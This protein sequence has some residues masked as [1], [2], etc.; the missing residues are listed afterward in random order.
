M[1]FN[2]LHRWD[3]S[4]TEA[5]ALQNQLVPHVIHDQPLDL[6]KIRTI[7]GVDVSVKTADGGRVTSDQ[8]LNAISSAAVVV[9]SFPSLE[10]I[11]TVTASI[12][13]PFPYVPGLLAF[14]EGPVLQEAFAQ[15]QTEPDAL[16]FDG[17][18]R[19]HPRRLGIACHLGLWL[20]KPT[21]GCGKTL[22]V[23]T[24]I[25]PEAQ[26]GA[27]TDL[28][29][30]GE[31]VGVS[32]RSKDKVKPIFISCGHLIDLPSSIALTLQCTRDYRLPEPIRQA[33]NA[34]GKV[35]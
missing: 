9:L 24:Y 32:L 31:V 21:L 13:T 29:D 6:S 17:M 7:A 28:V 33:H 26:R 30:K 35:L 34:A 15:L 14:R 27:Y 2:I 19:A 10:V 16:M 18:G 8:S 23:G 22:F 25:E 4:P 11:E 12:P 20:Q 3:I 5:I 1:K